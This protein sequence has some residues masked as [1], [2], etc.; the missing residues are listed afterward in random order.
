MEG[1]RQRIVHKKM[2]KKIVIS[3][4]FIIVMGFNLNTVVEADYESWEEDG[5]ESVWY[6][7][8]G[9][10]LCF[11]PELNALSGL[12]TELTYV[13][14]PETFDGVEV[15]EIYYLRSANL[16]QVNIPNTVNRIGFYAFWGCSGLTEMTIPDSV[17]VIDV[18]AFYGC[19]NLTSI[20]LSNNIDYIASSTFYECTS[21]EEITIP[22]G[23]TVIDEDAFY[24]C[25]SL[26]EVI[27]PSGVTTI[28]F[29]ALGGCSSLTTVYLPHSIESLTADVFSG[30]E[31][32]TDIYYYGTKEE[33]SA[34]DT[35]EANISDSITVHYMGNDMSNYPQPEDS[36]SASSQGN[37]VSTRVNEEGEDGE[38]N[39]G[40]D[41]NYFTHSS[42]YK[43]SGFYGVTNYW[44]NDFDRAR[45]FAEATSIGTYASLTNA[46]Y[47]NWAGSCAGISSVMGAVYNGD[48]NISDI[49]SSNATSFHELGNPAQ[50][51]DLLSTINYYQLQQFISNVI[52]CNTKSYGNWWLNKI[53][54]MMNTY[55]SAVL[56][57]TAMEYLDNGQCLVL[58]MHTDSHRILIVDYEYNSS[59]S[60][61]EFVLY[62][63][64]TVSSAG[65]SGEFYYWYVSENLEE[66]YTSSNCS[67]NINSGDEYNLSLLLPG[68]AIAE[69]VSDGITFVLDSKGNYIIEME[70]GKCIY[71]EDQ[72]ITI[73]SAV[74][75]TLLSTIMYDDNEDESTKYVFKIDEAED[76][77]ITDIEGDID[78][79]I[80]SNDAYVSLAGSNMDSASIVLGEGVVVEGEDYEFESFVTTRE[81]NEDGTPN[82]ISVSGTAETTAEIEVSENNIEVVSEGK[83]KDL[84]TTS[85]LEGE[86]V[87]VSTESG[88][89][90]IYIIIGGI[91]V[92]LLVGGIVIMKKKRSVN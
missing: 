43:T 42:S 53:D 5:Y 25:S 16:T 7:V 80:Y 27:I 57:Q 72:T 63:M 2:W 61:Y 62:D 66:F 28:W 88:S 12:T 52:I 32:L 46:M 45:L 31:N 41:N 60:R 19:S 76:F 11:I 1:M 92:V 65:D 36:T 68:S 59:K 78:I 4:M 17:T 55:N 79:A 15:N 89:Y 56:F 44:L 6:A 23:V 8:E 64:N 48:I 71:C 29:A 38:F 14:I 33:W 74:S 35:E 81:L 82:V 39:L 37:D 34:I 13:N 51:L 54:N 40:I 90:K 9:G 26:K 75:G 69:D 30:S 77:N 91:V 84:T 49:T 21:L 22:N 70:N 86:I 18:A 83:I 87:S 20:K 50:D 3:L 85:Y 10:E 24:G 58:A 73:S 47:S 67:Y